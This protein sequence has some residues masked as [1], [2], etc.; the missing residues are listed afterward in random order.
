[1]ARFRQTTLNRGPAPI[2]KKKF[3]R[4]TS[5]ITNSAPAIVATIVIEETGTIYSAAVDLLTYS[6]TPNAG[7]IQE[8]NVG[9]TCVPESFALP[10][11]SD[12]SNIETMNGFHV[13][14]T[15]NTLEDRIAGGT[16]EYGQMNHIR[17]KFRFRRKCDRNTSVIMFADT[18]VREGAAR[19]VRIVGTLMLVIR[20]R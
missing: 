20:V 8:L 13:G 5:L 18:I 3:V 2:F 10:D 9:L 11:Y 19:S 6:V 14:N 17:E 12:A 7:D 1:M 15:W 4:F 16:Q